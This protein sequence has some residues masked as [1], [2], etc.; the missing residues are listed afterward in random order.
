MRINKISVKEY[1]PYLCWLILFFWSCFHTFFYDFSKNSGIM[2]SQSS[3]KNAVDSC[4][5]KQKLSGQIRNDAYGECEL[6]GGH[7]V[8][9]GLHILWKSVVVMAFIFNS[10]LHFHSQTDWRPGRKL[11]PAEICTCRG[12]IQIYVIVASL[13]CTIVCFTKTLFFNN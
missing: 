5:L 6:Y 2:L 4:E 12:E 8:Q 11:L 10:Y 7:L 3:A 1:F 9:V 13:P